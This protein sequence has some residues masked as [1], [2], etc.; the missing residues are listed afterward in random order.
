MC[1]TA[2]ERSPGARTGHI[3]LLD[4]GNSAVSALVIRSRGRIDDLGDKHICMGLS[5]SSSNRSD[6]SFRAREMNPEGGRNGRKKSSRDI[7][8]R[9]N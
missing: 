4:P 1:V 2:A 3:Q 9:Q 7:L 6:P 5:L 8:T